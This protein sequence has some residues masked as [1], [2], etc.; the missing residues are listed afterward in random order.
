MLEDKLQEYEH[1]NSVQDEKAG[2]CAPY[3]SQIYFKISTKAITK[4]S[5]R[6]TSDQVRK[7]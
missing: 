5:R 6:A 1:F 2:L 4:Y 7:D 3:L